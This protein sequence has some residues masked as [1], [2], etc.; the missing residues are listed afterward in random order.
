[1]LVVFGLNREIWE[2]IGPSERKL[3]TLAA[4]F[5]LAGLT[6]NFTAGVRFM[7]QLSDSYLIGIIG[8]LLVGL[9]VS[10]VVRIALITLISRPLLP[11][12]EPKSSS[13]VPVVNTELTMQGRILSVLRSL[14]DFSLIFRFLIIT[15]MAIVVAM[16]IA[17][18]VGW[19][20]T[21]RIQQERRL[22]VKMQFKEN[23]PDM[24]KNQEAILD[25][26]L[27][28]EHFPIHIYKSLAKQPA[29]VLSIWICAC[30]FLIPF[31]LLWYL[32]SNSQFDYAR[33]NKQLLVKQIEADYAMAT[34]RLRQTQQKKFGLVEAILPNQAW[35]DAPFNTR[36]VTAKTHYEFESPEIIMERLKSL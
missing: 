14:P 18:V 20:S 32:R 15:L 31:F 19:N 25:E 7:F 34:A 12:D 6:L 17:S 3:F 26:N 4:W 29:G 22:E 13:E 2:K 11:D 28:Q 24:T 30:G 8:G 16:P 27:D 36:K 23:H 21:N 33:L 5:F 35:K 1:M 9:I 10:M